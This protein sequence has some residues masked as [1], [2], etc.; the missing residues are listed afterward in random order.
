M[1]N[2]VWVV[3]LVSLLVAVACFEGRQRGPCCEAHATDNLDVVE[4]GYCATTGR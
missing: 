4:I 1:P 3:L 2:W